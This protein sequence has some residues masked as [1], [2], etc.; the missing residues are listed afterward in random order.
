[1]VSTSKVSDSKRKKPYREGPRREMT[2]AW[3]QSVRDALA[4]NKV[5]KKFPINQSQLSR[6]LGLLRGTEPPDRTAITHMFAGRSSGLVDDICQ[7]LGIPP[8]M[9]P[10]AEPDSE[11]EVVEMVRRLPHE[12]QQDVSDFIRR[13]VLPRLSEND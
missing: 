3:K 7:V 8:P 2:A 4:A 5:A 11:P 12:A 9:V 1:M 6:A 13:F 10:H